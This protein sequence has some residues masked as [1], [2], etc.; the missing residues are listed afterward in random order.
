MTQPA[1]RRSLLLSLLD[2][3]GETA[4]RL[5]RELLLRWTQQALQLTP[6]MAVGVSSENDAEEH[7]AW[8][9][10]FATATTGVSGLRCVSRVFIG[11]LR[12]AGCGNRGRFVGR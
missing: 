2:M 3:S 12:V 4:F 5:Q 11:S 1:F 10:R 6:T 8:R 9:G 7:A